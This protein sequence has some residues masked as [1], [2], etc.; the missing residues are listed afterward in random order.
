MGG[1]PAAAQGLVKIEA[2]LKAGLHELQ[3]RVPCCELVSL[4]IQQDDE[5]VRSGPI[6]CF[7]E[8]GRAPGR[9]E[10]LRLGQTLPFDAG[11]RCEAALHVP[12][13]SDHRSAVARQQCRLIG[14]R[15]IPSGGE[16]APVEHRGKEGSGEPV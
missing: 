15:G 1:M 9:S 12:Q 8:D 11:E 3:G 4:G 10:L 5:A 6:A 14:D 2:G 7:G 13:G 16:A